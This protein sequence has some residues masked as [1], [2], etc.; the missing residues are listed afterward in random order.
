MKFMHVMMLIVAVLP[1]CRTPGGKS[2]LSGIASAPAKP[3]DL[4]NSK[5]KFTASDL[6]AINDH[7]SSFCKILE[8]DKSD[9]FVHLAAKLCDGEQNWVGYALADGLKDQNEI[10]IANRAAVAD[11][12]MRLSTAA[13]QNNNVAIQKLVSLE[14]QLLQQDMAIISGE[15]VKDFENE[16]ENPSGG[17]A[18]QRE[19]YAAFVAWIKQ[20]NT[21]YSKN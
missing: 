12:A 20:L 4:P 14:Q 19:D 3:S 7:G 2:G 9:D 18:K 10:F 8:K 21:Y 13:K 16:M 1:A 5:I 11:V 15:K 6:L 17:V